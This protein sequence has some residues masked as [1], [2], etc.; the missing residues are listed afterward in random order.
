MANDDKSP[1]EYRHAPEV[2]E[3]ARKLIA[4]VAD[5]HELVNAH[6]VYVFRTK[7]S[8]SRGH[9]TWGK[10]RKPTGL[11]AW[12]ANPEQTHDVWSEPWPFFVIEIAWDV[13]QRL[14]DGQKVALVDHELCHCAVGYSEDGELQL[15]MRHHDV[16]EFVGVIKRN[17]LWRESVQDIGRVSAEQLELSFERVGDTSPSVAGVPLQAIADGVGGEVVNGEIHV[18]L[19]NPK[20]TRRS[21]AK[22]PV[23]VG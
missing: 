18:D 16:E 14:D 21:R 9:E 10:A 15:S 3:I 6:I 1:L 17:G 19:D 4:A 2:A 5:H 7:A 12:L 11:Q 20:R 23:G 13:W 22:T 8:K